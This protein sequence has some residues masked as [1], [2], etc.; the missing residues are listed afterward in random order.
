[1]NNSKRFFIEYSEAACAYIVYDRSRKVPENSNGF[2]ILWGTDHPDKYIVQAE[3]D[4]LNN[5]SNYAKERFGI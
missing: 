4:K 5:D 3:C 2:A 1:M